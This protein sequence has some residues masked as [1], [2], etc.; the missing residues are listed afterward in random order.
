LD[1]LPQR[2]TQREL[3][4]LWEL[5]L[6]RRELFLL[7]RTEDTL[8]AVHAAIERLARAMEVAA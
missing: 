7:A 5:V 8:I 1:N 3:E 2:P 6:V 4:L